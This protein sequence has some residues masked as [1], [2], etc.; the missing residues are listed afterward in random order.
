V[1]HRL[2]FALKLILRVRWNAQVVP[3]PGSR[4][5]PALAIII[6]YIPYK[7]TVLTIKSILKYNVGRDSKSSYV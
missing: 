4:K 1:G 6:Y 2:M 3:R 7:V 5:R